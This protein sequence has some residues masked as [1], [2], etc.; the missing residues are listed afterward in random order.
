MNMKTRIR[1]NAKT[2]LSNPHSK[3]GY[4]GWPTVTRLQNGSLAVVCS[5]YRCG[6]ICPFGKLVM[7]TSEDEGDTWTGAVPL[8]DTPLDDRDGG[9]CTFGR[10]GVMV[11]SFNNSIAAQR[12]WNP[13]N[14]YYNAYL[15]TLTAADEETYLGS[16]FRLSFDGGKTF[17]P[18][19]RSPVSSP[20]GPTQLHDGTLLWVGRVFSAD[21]SFGEN[22]SVHAYAVHADGH[23]EFRG[24]VP[25]ADMGTRVDLCEPHAIELPDGR[26]LCH[27]RS[28]RGYDFSTFQ[29]ESAD[30]GRTWS[31]PIPLLPEHGGAPAHLLLHSS[32]ILISA[33]G[34]RQPPYGI[35]LMLSADYGRTWQKDVPLF[36]DSVS[37]DL[38]YPATVELQNGS[39]LTVFYAKDAPDGPAVIKQIVWQIEK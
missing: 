10:N 31:T 36:T 35:R 29:T 4:F 1:E 33:Y 38:G 5:G 9:I 3:H 23:M 7:A 30:G 34:Y 22:S 6:H 26:L 37:G 14:A 15:D 18:I 11:T 27:I 24:A 8:I 19:F 32:G 2:I 28:E 13:E 16:Q 20:H 21:D 25:A 12:A 39:L 17:G